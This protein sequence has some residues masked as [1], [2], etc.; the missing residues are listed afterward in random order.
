[1]FYFKLILLSMFTISC[2][3][4]E[5]NQSRVK[6]YQENDSQENVLPSDSQD[7]VKE[8]D[9]SKRIDTEEDNESEENSNSSNS[10]TSDAGSMDSG[11]RQVFAL[12]CADPGDYINSKDDLLN[13]LKEACKRKD[14]FSKDLQSLSSNSNASS[15]S[16]ITLINLLNKE[17]S[18]Y[19]DTI[20]LSGFSIS[21]TNV[22]NVSDV[23]QE[24]AKESDLFVAEQTENSSDFLA[25]YEMQQQVNE[26]PI[27]VNYSFEKIFYSH[28]SGA[29]L[30]ADSIIEIAD[31]D[32]LTEKFANLTILIPRDDGSV[33]AYIVINSAIKSTIN[34]FP[35]PA[36]TL[37]PRVEETVKSGIYDAL[38]SIPN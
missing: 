38:K 36:D 34:G 24:S 6:K 37:L 23:M 11:E 12:I 3:E 28:S 30:V 1:M 16:G 8:S 10:A 21:N 26:S 31:D 4:A 19:F 14:R 33:F 7:D 2:V 9:A 13:V 18:S 22:E 29:I 35:V 25:A 17:K 20:Y 27:T 5:Q 15:S 32:N